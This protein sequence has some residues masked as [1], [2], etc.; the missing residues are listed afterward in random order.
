MIVEFGPWWE[1]TADVEHVCFACVTDESDTLEH[2]V[3]LIK[4]REHG[5]TDEITWVVFCQDNEIEWRGSREL[6]AAKGQAQ[7]FALNIILA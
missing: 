5:T 6:P 3:K 1:Q 2:E 7:A 4:V